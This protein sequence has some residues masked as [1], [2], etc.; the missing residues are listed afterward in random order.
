MRLKP[1]EERHDAG[2]CTRSRSW[3]SCSAQFAAIPEAIIF[4]FNIPTISGFGA[5]AGFNFLLQDRSG[6]LSVERLGELSRQFAGGGAP[7]AGDRQHLHVVRPALSRRSR[8]S[9][10]ARRRASSAC[11]STR[12]SRPWPRASAALRQRLQP[13]RSPLPRLRPGRGGLPP[14]AR[15]HRRHLGAQQDHQRDDPAR[16]RSSRSRRRAGTELTNRFNLLRSVEFNGVPGAGFASGQALAALEEVFKADDAAGD[17]LR[18][19]A[20]S[21]QEKIA[22]PAGPTCVAA[23]VLRLP[24]ARRDVRE[25]AAALGGA[26]RLA[27]RR[28]RRLLRR[29]ARAATTTTSTCRSATSC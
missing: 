8:W 28:A 22:P 18:L 3:R 14:Q 4:P 25:L 15:G 23:I 12:P 7:A 11:R 21:Y 9:S 20:L 29:L 27:A 10:T 13:V 16:R 24:A 17:G 19:L 2:A 5:S 6:S 1:W 26:A